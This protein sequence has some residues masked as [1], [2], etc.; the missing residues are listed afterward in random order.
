M[1]KKQVFVGSLHFMFVVTSKGAVLSCFASKKLLLLVY[2]LGQRIITPLPD[3]YHKAMKLNDFRQTLREG[4][5]RSLADGMAALPVLI[6]SK[7]GLEFGS[8]I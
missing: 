1:T 4:C 7:G 5:F 3:C 6:P 2:Y 8:I